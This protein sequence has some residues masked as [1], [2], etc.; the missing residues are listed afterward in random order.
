MVSIT[1]CSE[2]DK[3]SRLDIGENDVTLRRNWLVIRPQMVIMS[4][5]EVFKH[6]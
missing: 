4:L 6:A 5:S 2:A 3:N 1:I